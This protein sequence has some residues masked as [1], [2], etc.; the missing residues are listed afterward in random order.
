M[1]LSLTV[2]ITIQISYTFLAVY[3]PIYFKRLNEQKRK[4]NILHLV[5]FLAGIVALLFPSLV[6]LGVGG[7]STLDTKFPPVVCFA[8]NRD[9]SAYMLLI[10]LGVLT[11]LIITELILIF[12]L[13][14]R[15]LKCID[16]V[17]KIANHGWTSIDTLTISI[18][19]LFLTEIDVER[20]NPRA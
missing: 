16:C 2:W 10:P 13:L 9:V 5:S 6:T 20:R 11:A 7:Y 4:K 3:A 12:R 8:T 19:F 14:V 15:Y 1:V 18:L 17:N